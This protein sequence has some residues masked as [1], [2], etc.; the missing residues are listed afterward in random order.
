[1]SELTAGRSPAPT[2][3]QEAGVVVGLGLR[4]QTGVEELQALVEACLAAAGVAPAR[5]SRIAT[6][7][8]R[9]DHPAIEAL[10]C[11]YGAEI[12]ALPPHGL[13]RRVPNPS[14]RVAAL[15]GMP[16]VAEAAALAFGPLLLEKRR[17]PG[18][19]CA[20]ALDR[21]AYAES[22]SSAAST[23]STSSAGP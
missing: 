2:A 23:L 16:S 17:S 18:A 7:D 3:S 1:M 12:S 5:V 9:R 20:L 10:A 19:T 4:R 13:A 21:S 22:A 14:A 11:R 6:L 8:A 15:A